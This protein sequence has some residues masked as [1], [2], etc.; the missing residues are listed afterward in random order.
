MK[1]FERKLVKERVRGIMFI[2]I[3]SMV[4]L[5]TIAINLYSESEKTV[6]EVNN[7]FANKVSLDLENNMEK[8]YYVNRY[9]EDMKNL[10]K[11]DYN[12]DK[13]LSHINK[14]SNNSLF[15]YIGVVSKDGYLNIGSGEKI[16]VGDR[17]YFKKSIKGNKFV[18]DIVEG[19]LKT[20]QNIV[21]SRP[22]IIDNKIE[23]VIVGLENEK[24]L[25]KSL[26]NNIFSDKIKVDIV[27][28][29]GEIVI[30]SKG[31]EKLYSEDID[32]IIVKYKDDKIAKFHEG[33]KN[34]TMAYKKIENTNLYAVSVAPL[35]EVFLG[36]QNT[37][38]IAIVG[39]ILILISYA[40]L[41]TNKDI[42]KAREIKET[43]EIDTLTKLRNLVKFKLDCKEIISKK[44]DEDTYILTTF[45]IKN[46][47]L[48]NELF[49]YDSG[50]EL[51]KLVANN[52]LT[53]DFENVS[54][55]IGEDIFTILF[56]LK[57]N[58]EL[59]EKINYLINHITKYNYT[60]NKIDLRI[61]M[62]I[63]KLEN[64]V[65]IGK[66]IDNANSARMEA[67]KICSK[68]SSYYLYNCELGYKIHQK[69]IVERDL[70]D[71]LKNDEI[72]VVYQ[73]KVNLKTEKIVSAEALIRWKHKDVGYIPPDIFISIA[74]KNGDIHLIGKWVVEKVCSEIKKCNEN[75]ERIVP[76]SINLSREELYQTDLTDYIVKT[77]KKYEINPNLLEFEITETAALNDVEFIN[78][79][80]KEIRAFGVKISMDDFGTGM[81]TLC[82]LKKLDIDT[83]KIDRSMAIDVETNERT[84]ALL[85]SIINLA[86]EYNT[87]VVCEGIENVKQV[88]ILKSF[89]CDMIQGYVYYKPLNIENFKKCLF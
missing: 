62:G 47:K 37:I 72:S 24:I 83:L 74:E 49:G 79:K 26:V 77:I 15:S 57:N 5:I 43:S 70:K 30:A 17:N 55:R 22:L 20:E 58:E 48:I 69:L 45:D 64:K 75:N 84:R 54:A 32:Q 10:Y 12:E 68:N 28:E 11:D 2:S 65:H 29:D 42:K 23:G 80:I 39:I 6:I 87:D 82:N 76:I 50:D 31:E 78:E 33:G 36:T 59:D 66:A 86:K 81:S 8:L 60:K 34:Y 40:I 16:Y 1:I 88:E 35:R 53:M 7:Q 9:I 46:F 71:A 63:F 14:V 3:I 25:Q 56:K 61:N 51:L 73:P 44:K 18:S 27:N 13:E 89:N 67:K 41:A 85:K 4:F 38:A 19:R 21:Y 52:I